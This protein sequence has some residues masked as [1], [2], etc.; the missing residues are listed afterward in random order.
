MV[1]LSE[2]QPSLSDSKPGLTARP[3][4][5]RK[6]RQ[7][8]I[9]H[10]AWGAAKQQKRR[11]LLVSIYTTTLTSPEAYYSKDP[12]HLRVSIVHA[13]NAAHTASRTPGISMKSHQLASR[14]HI[15]VPTIA[16][17][18]PS[19]LRL[20]LVVGLPL[21]EIWYDF[22]PRPAYHA[23]PGRGSKPCFS[24][25]GLAPKSLSLR[26]WTW[27]HTHGWG[28]TWSLG[29]EETIACPPLGTPSPPSSSPALAA[30]PAT[31]RPW[32]LVRRNTLRVPG[33]SKVLTCHSAH[34]A[35]HPQIALPPPLFRLGVSPQF[36]VPPTLLVT[37]H[38]PARERRSSPQSVSP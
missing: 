32:L 5:R 2:F 18:Q 14:P 11:V 30:Q 27:A 22:W 1:H 37:M 24:A 9:H 10:Q 19:R 6:E 25:L 29:E 28:G 4:A 23:M 33:N 13:Q 7:N 34:S 17:Y 35:E 31:S 26:P 20:S 3:R 8:R 15:L 38:P 21:R 36:F 12:S 16:N